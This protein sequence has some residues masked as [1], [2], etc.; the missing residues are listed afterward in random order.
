MVAVGTAL[1]FTLAGCTADTKEWFDVP[2]GT[3][4]PADTTEQD[5]LYGGSETARRLL[6]SGAALNII[7]VP[8][9]N[10]KTAKQL[11]FYGDKE[12]KTFV[13]DLHRS[14]GKFRSR[15]AK[16]FATATLGRYKPSAVSYKKAD[17]I[18]L[19][20]G[21][22]DYWHMEE[23]DPLYAAIKKAAQPD[24]L[25]VAI[26]EAFACKPPEGEAGVAGFASTDNIPIIMKSSL[27]D[28]D[29][30]VIHEAGHYLGLSHAGTAE[31]DDATRLQ[32][33][34]V[35]ETADDW[36]VMSYRWAQEFTVPELYKLGLLRTDEVVDI[37]TTTVGRE[38]TMTDM[39]RKDGV[40][41]VLGKTATGNDL[42]LSW[43]KDFYAGFREK[44]VRTKD[45]FT[46]LK[47]VDADDILYGSVAYN[48]KTGK[49][50]YYVCYEVDKTKQDHSLQMRVSS[51][52]VD[53]KS[54]GEDIDG[55]F[56][57]VTPKGQKIKGIDDEY[58]NQNRS[59]MEPP[60]TV[61]AG[62]TPI[63]YVSADRKKA[64]VRIG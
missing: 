19:E 5:P 6:G 35:S 49:P 46:D 55:S 7:D 61:Y 31:C 51:N 2:S 53:G 42:Y 36:S 3:H 54:D 43:N 23:L 57:I 38:V 41:L 45:Q 14:N 52:A 58:Q 22:V 28:I 20:G 17:P 16:S 26:V 56:V 13:K 15:I 27:N 50:A 44:C 21:C 10:A 59:F 63:T 4:A 48:K 64:V 1:A 37:R 24:K 29:H 11:D 34:E 40:K 39:S 47:G 12:A 8:V 25:N 9:P 62:T 18:S 33:C 32:G 30:T 60:E